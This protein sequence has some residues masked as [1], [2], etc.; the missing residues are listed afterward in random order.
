[1]RPISEQIVQRLGS[2]VSPLNASALWRR[3][4][5]QAGVSGEPRTAVDR[6]RLVA[7]L[8]NGIAFFVSDPVGRR[9][10]LSDVRTA[11]NAGDRSSPS[12]TRFAIRA[13]HDI[14]AA[15]S[16]ARSLA[17]SLGANG[18]SAQKVTT[19]VSELARNIVS[20]TPGG[21]LTLTST[22]SP[23]PLVRIVSTDEGKGIAN[24]DEILRGAY[25]S[26]TGLGRGILGCKRLADRFEI[27]SNSSGTRI[28]VDVFV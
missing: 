8:E 4:C 17:E 13:E 16:A 23:K 25:R 10:A 20:Y 9:R 11:L 1:M 28:A 12:S 27:D 22:P 6:E 7:A 18:F 3:A 14:S 24:L 2:Y 15:R 26:R 5:E 19:I 21:E